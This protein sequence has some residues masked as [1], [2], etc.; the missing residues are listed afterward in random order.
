MLSQILSLM[1]LLLG[2]ADYWRDK[3]QEQRARVAAYL[4]SVSDCL[5]QIAAELRAGRTPHSGCAELAHYAQ[6]LPPSVEELLAW[7]A[8]TVLRGLKLAAA[9]RHAAMHA[10][11]DASNAHKDLAAIEE[12]AGKVRALAVTLAVG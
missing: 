12:T 9:S 8:H 1:N 2:R 3:S 4:Q 6:E 5:T 7:E 11:D 10:K